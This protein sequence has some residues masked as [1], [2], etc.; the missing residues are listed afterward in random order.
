MTVRLG[1]TEAENFTDRHEINPINSPGDIFVDKSN[2]TI[3]RRFGR[4]Y[5][6]LRAGRPGLQRACQNA[7]LDGT[8]LSPQWG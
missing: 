1:A 6:N 8:L 4:R 3:G 2:N 5:T 7:V